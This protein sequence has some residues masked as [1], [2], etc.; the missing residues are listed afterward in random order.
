[1]K[2]YY[3]FKSNYTGFGH[4]CAEL[5]DFESIGFFNQ[6]SFVYCS[7]RWQQETN[8]LV[9]I[10][11]DESSNSTNLVVANGIERFKRVIIIQASIAKSER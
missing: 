7:G 9:T 5:N 2:E 3:I 1:M 10:C 6:D 11:F 8:S 4:I